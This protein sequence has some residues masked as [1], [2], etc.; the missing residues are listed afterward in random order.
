MNF[1]TMQ[2]TKKVKLG[3]VFQLD[4]NTT[5][6]LEKEYL[7]SM[8]YQHSVIKS[9]FSDSLLR[10]VR[11]EILANLE[12][13]EKETDIYKVNQTGD[14]ANL[15]KLPPSELAMLSN[16]FELRN[17]IYSR[18]F[19]EF[20][21]KITGVSGLSSSNVDLSINNYKNGCHLLNHDDV[22]GTRAVSF[23]LYLPD[24]DVEWL[25]TDGGRLELYPVV[26]MGTPANEPSKM[27]L[28][29]WNTFAF[30]AVQPG[31]S[32]HSVEE[33]FGEKERLSISGWFHFAQP[34]EPEYC[35]QPIQAR[36]EGKS[37][38]NQLLEKDS[39]GVMDYEEEFGDLE[40]HDLE[41]L[42]KYL[43][44]AYLQPRNLN[45][46]T[47]VFK[48]EGSLELHH[49]LNK[50]VEELVH[51]ITDHYDSNLA[52]NIQSHG[53]AIPDGWECKGPPHLMRYV[54]MIQ[55]DGLFGELRTFFRGES[56]RK[57]V[58]QV[59]GL[60]P[61]SRRVQVRR[62]RPSLDYTLALSSPT[63]FLDVNLSLTAVHEDFCDGDVGG[64]SNYMNPS[65]PNSDAAIYSKISANE[66]DE[67]LTTGA[68]WN[69]L[70]IV[71]RKP[72]MLKFIKY[73]SAS[74]PWSRWDIEGEYLCNTD[75]IEE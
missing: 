61:I 8:P 65:D 66:D 16:L 39:V 13:T 71:R 74:A 54:S 36:K 45:S 62:F 11:E 46:V 20:I 17:A 70:H 51:N 58:N 33:V 21:Q 69:R 41:I 31:Y 48:N 49:F 47:E 15:D 38:L 57:W 1:F 2:P 56:F 63:S 44:P 4:L 34:G 30:F 10:K 22:I 32:F 12:F 6:E 5:S 72:G 60:V 26:E 37:T 52:N 53:T 50:Q 59:T 19:R 18:S 35:Q 23:I 55:D 28:P 43:N 3:N 64:Y 7:E 40:A 25:A 75:V 42:K 29:V 14:L 73:V 67:L 68:F 9:L 27:V 24:P